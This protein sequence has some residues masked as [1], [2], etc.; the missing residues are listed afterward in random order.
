MTVCDIT[1]DNWP[2]LY[3]ARYKKCNPSQYILMINDRKDKLAVTNCIS[4][5]FVSEIKQILFRMPKIDTEFPK[6]FSKNIQSMTMY[7]NIFKGQIQDEDEIYIFC[8]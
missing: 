2:I 6:K 8:L 7:Y 1:L 5:V 4:V 3:L